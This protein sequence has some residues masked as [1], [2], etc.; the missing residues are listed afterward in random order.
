MFGLFKKRAEGSAG[1]RQQ[2]AEAQTAREA[3][4]AR[5]AEMEPRRGAVLVDASE[6]EAVRFEA[7]LAASRDDL[8]RLDH[9]VT[10]L[11][12]RATEAAQQERRQAQEE[13]LHILKA[14]IQAVTR[15][16]ADDYPKFARAIAD[17]L[18]LENKVLGEII[19]LRSAGVSLGTEFNSPRRALMSPAFGFVSGAL[20]DTVVLPSVDATETVWPLPPRPIVL[21]PEE[22]AR[23]RAADLIDARARYQHFSGWLASIEARIADAKGNGGGSDYHRFIP[24]STK[25][26]MERQRDRLRQ[27][28]AEIAELE[29]S[30]QPEAVTL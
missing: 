23:R 4:V 21:S 24:D 1:L 27:I 18:D 6:S 10:T 3:V 14:K 25:P 2:L 20:G 11:A 22:Q 13:Q 7:E 17:I 15:M 28:K 8:T 5:I 30:I 12:T 26:A 16:L 9:V 19:A 29:A